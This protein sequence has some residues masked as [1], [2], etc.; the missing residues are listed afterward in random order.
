[1]LV[2]FIRLKKKQVRI[3]CCPI[4]SATPWNDGTLLNISYIPPVE[5]LSHVKIHHRI[6]WRSGY[7][8]FDSTNKMSKQMIFWERTALGSLLVLSSLSQFSSTS[9][10][11]LD[12]KLENPA[13]PAF[14][15]SVDN[16]NTPHTPT[17]HLLSVHHF[18]DL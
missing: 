4:L 13:F 2:W 12:K 3:D 14:C 9:L 6:Q 5:P 7:D 15:H 10:A 8:T 1:M 17:H 16:L 18:Q 11:S